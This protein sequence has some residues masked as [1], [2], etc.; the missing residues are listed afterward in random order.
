MGQGNQLRRIKTM[1]GALETQ[2]GATGVAGAMIV[3]MYGL[4]KT[5]VMKGG[6]FASAK[7][8]L[9]QQRAPPPKGGGAN[10]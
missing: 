1:D 9:L 6:R 5:C 3:T 10:K 4:K 8:L 2:A 7:H